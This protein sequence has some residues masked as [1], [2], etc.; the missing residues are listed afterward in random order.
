M[1]WFLQSGHLSALKWNPFLST[2]AGCIFLLQ[3]LHRT[4]FSNISVRNQGFLPTSFE[5]VRMCIVC[6]LVVYT[7]KRFWLVASDFPNYGVSS[8]GVADWD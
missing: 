8:G 5:L 1:I 7:L 6:I 2:V 4:V 3:C